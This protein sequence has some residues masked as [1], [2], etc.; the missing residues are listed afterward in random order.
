M[1][2]RTPFLSVIENW[3]QWN[4]ITGISLALALTLLPVIDILDPA[5][6][7]PP[8]GLLVDFAGFGVLAG[9]SQAV[10]LHLQVVSLA[11]WLIA[12]AAGSATAGLLMALFLQFA[13]PDAMVEA[14]LAG[15]VAGSFQSMALSVPSQR[16]AWILGTIL[17]W[18]AAG[19]TAA[20]LFISRGSIPPTAPFELLA[21]VVVGWVLIALVLFFALLVLFPKPDV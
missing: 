9:L 2:Q 4:V 17:G 3:L 21:S 6:L 16:R 14:T 5:V 13:L 15:V 19:G 10:F 1:S 11:R 7:P 20:W 12:S 8:I 18:M